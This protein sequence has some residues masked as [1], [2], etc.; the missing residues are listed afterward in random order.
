M[1]HISFNDIQDEVER[2]EEG[3][4]IHGLIARVAFNRSGGRRRRTARHIW[5]GAK[6]DITHYIYQEFGVEYAQPVEAR[7]KQ[8]IESHAHQYQDGDSLHNWLSAQDRVAM[9]ISG[10]IY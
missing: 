6:Y 1:P 7:V 3:S 10:L 2:S 4:D 5:E 8:F 9:T